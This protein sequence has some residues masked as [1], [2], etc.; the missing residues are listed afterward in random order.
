MRAGYWSTFRDIAAAQTSWRRAQQVADRLP[1]EDPDRT[2]MRIEPRT[3]LAVQRLASRRQPVRADIHFDELR[4]LCTAAGDQRS[5]AIGL[6]ALVTA[7]AMKHIAA[8]PLVSPTNSSTARRHR[9]PDADD[10]AVDVDDVGQ[11]RVCS[12]W[13]TLT[14]RAAHDRSGRRGS[15]GKGNL[16]YRVPHWPWRW[17]GEALRASASGLQGWKDDLRDATATAREFAR[18]DPGQRD[19]V[20]VHVRSPLRRIVARRGRPPRYRRSIVVG[21][22]IRRRSCPR[23]C[24][25]RSRR[26]TLHRSGPAAR[27]RSRVA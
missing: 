4:E 24:S 27:N 22:T 15:H 6:S 14:D 21:R 23:R 5:L 1:D 17:L 25:C 12:R 20:R 19:V 11:A 16:L 26:H 13:P 3:V 9:R 10:R 2:S 8:R 7:H 18:V